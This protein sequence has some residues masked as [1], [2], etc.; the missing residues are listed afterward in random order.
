MN[1]WALTK[2]SLPQVTLQEAYNMLA[3]LAANCTW[4]YA[5]DF[6]IV[7]RFLI[8]ERIELFEIHVPKI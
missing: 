4:N 8:L 2:Y 5:L 1:P 7:I 6:T 3:K